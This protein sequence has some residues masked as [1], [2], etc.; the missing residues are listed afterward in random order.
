LVRPLL[1]LMCASA[2]VAVLASLIG[3]ALT[4]TGV[5][6]VHPRWAERIPAEQHVAFLA[7]GWAHTASYLSGGMGGTMLIFATIFGRARAARAARHVAEKTLV[8]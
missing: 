1:I 4:S 7:A 3:A 5:I 8:A 6:W 2:V